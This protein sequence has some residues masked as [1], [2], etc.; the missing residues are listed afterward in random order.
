MI[1]TPESH[2]DHPVVGK[3]FD[4]YDGKI[5]YC[6]SYDS[7]CGFWMTEYKNPENRKNVSE[8]AIDKTFHTINSFGGIGFS[9]FRPL[10]K[11]DEMPTK[12][13]HEKVYE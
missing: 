6:D 3:F 10:I 1:K 5:Y 12:E 13:M 2:P 7:S 8:R 4:A 9:R 11:K